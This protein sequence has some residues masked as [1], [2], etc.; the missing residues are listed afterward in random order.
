MFFISEPNFE[1]VSP[2]SQMAKGWQEEPAQ[3]LQPVGDAVTVELRVVNTRF[4]PVSVQLDSSW[5]LKNVSPVNKLL[6]NK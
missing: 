3:L 4:D 6:L 1:V 5:T 2:S